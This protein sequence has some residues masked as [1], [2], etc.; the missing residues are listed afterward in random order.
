MP[1]CYLKF[2]NKIYLSIFILLTLLFV[3]CQKPVGHFDVVEKQPSIFPDYSGI[4]IPPN[5]AP[6]NFNINEPGTDFYV[7]ISSTNGDNITLRQNSPKIE[8]P[9]S[10]WHDL[11]EKNKNSALTISIYCYNNKWFR[12]KPVVDT[13]ANEPVESYLAYRLI[14]AVY[15]FWR[16]M[17]IYQRNIENFDESEIFV[18]RTSNLG[19]VN[20]HSFCKNNPLKMSLHLRKEFPG[21]LIFNK[22]QLIKINTK[23]KYT[24]AAC[25]YPSWHPGGNF[26]AYSVNIINQSFSSDNH[27]LDEVSDKASDIV[28]YNI[29]T[30]T[31]TTSPKVSTKSRENLPTW[32]PDGKWLYYISAPEAGELLGSRIITRYSLMKIYCNPEKNEWGEADTVLSAHKLGKSITFP[33]VSPD[34]RYI[35]FC[36]SDHGYFTIYDALSDIYLLDLTNG[37]YRKMNISST[38][39]ESYHAWAGS[40][41]WIVFSSKRIDDV[42][43]RPFFAYFD[44]DG[45]EHKPFV[46]PQ[47]DP[48]FYN[49][50][51][52]NYNIPEPITGR[53]PLNSR[54]MRDAA[55]KDPVNV[56]FDTTVD[57]DA[58]SGASRIKR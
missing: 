10:K 47:K 28:I 56:E 1:V 37:T 8:I 3:R 50:F 32:S 34:G 4:T 30:N 54:E 21:T 27:K 45:K 7:E 52:K 29:K 41:R 11:L 16:N 33:R 9:I 44:T 55:H 58:L 22:G 13:I 26:I 38:S 57:L 24:M 12:Y 43:S 36:L 5:I 49:A 15:V 31:L 23:T 2:W 20:C 39:N 48:L 19:C 53:V 6:L 35:M 25:V 51:F 18:N 14:N 42:Y 40:G 17:G 46:L